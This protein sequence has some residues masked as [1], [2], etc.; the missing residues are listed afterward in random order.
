[1]AAADLL[2][3]LGE[4]QKERLGELAG[5]VKC[6]VVPPWDRREGMGRAEEGKLQNVALYA[7]NLGEAHGYRQIL[8]AA[9]HLPA[10]WIVRFAVRG[11]KEKAL[12]RDAA[13]LA[14]VQ[15][16]EYV[17]EVETPAMLASARV[18]LITMSPGW[19]GVVVPSKLY[20]CVRTGRPVLFMGPEQSDT[21]REI[22]K[23]GWGEVLPAH[24][25]GEVVAQAMVRLGKAETKDWM[26]EDGAKRFA[27]AVVGNSLS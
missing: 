11:A 8:G 25:G 7:G 19:D 12:R 20:G 16:T 18:H 22:R 13:G 9:R 23:Y 27:A 26:A 6:V 10:E 2:V 17:S 5:K 1:L 14:H 4:V 15:V 21:A 24:A 3:C